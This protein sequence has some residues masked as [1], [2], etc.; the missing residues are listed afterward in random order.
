M[1]IYTID[2]TMI[3]Y[4]MVMHGHIDLQKSLQIGHAILTIRE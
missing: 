2:I 3:D 1:N 4:T